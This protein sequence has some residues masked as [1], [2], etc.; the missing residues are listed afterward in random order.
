MEKIYFEDALDLAKLM[1]YDINNDKD[2]SAVLF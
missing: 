2:S 1:L